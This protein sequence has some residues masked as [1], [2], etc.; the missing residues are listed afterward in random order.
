VDYT[1]LFENNEISFEEYGDLRDTV[2]KME[3]HQPLSSEM[4]N[5]VNAVYEDFVGVPLSFAPKELVVLVT[6]RVDYGW[7]GEN[8]FTTVVSLSVV[9]DERQESLTW[10]SVPI[11]VIFDATA[12]ADGLLAKANMADVCQEM[13]DRA[14]GK[15]RKIKATYMLTKH[16][17]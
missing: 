11:G 17:E 14:D 12:F 13:F 3:T 15:L 5:D 7:C 6:G 10:Q 16:R 2:I 1:L 4:I 9:G 8:E